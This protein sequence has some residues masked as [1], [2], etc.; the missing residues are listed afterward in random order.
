MALQGVIFFGVCLR[1]CAVKTLETPGFFDG[2][3][4]YYNNDLSEEGKK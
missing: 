4:I 2:K 1:N 3:C